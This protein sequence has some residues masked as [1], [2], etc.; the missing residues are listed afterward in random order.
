MSMILDYTLLKLAL[1]HNRQFIL[2]SLI[3]KL[4]KEITNYLYILN[5]YLGHLRVSLESWI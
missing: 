4:L 5:R 3:F 2:I 1:V